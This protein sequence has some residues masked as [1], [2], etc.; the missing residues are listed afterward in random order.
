MD[1]TNSKDIVLT[2][3]GESWHE[4]GFEANPDP[5]AIGPVFKGD[6]G[7][8]IAAIKKT[9]AM[10]LKKAFATSGEFEL[11][12]AGGTKVTVTPEMVNFEESLPEMAA[13]AEFDAGTIYVDA[14][15]TR[16]I[17]SEGF[18]REVIRRVQ[19]MRKELDLAVDE[20][21]K[22]HIRVEDERVV[23]L[24]L[25]FEQYIAKEIRADVQVIGLDV[26]STGELSKDWEVEGISISIGISPSNGE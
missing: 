16:E 9:D 13:S 22:A 8:V 20:S 21:I 18:A 4:L 1:Q 19:D 7:K 6:A 24:I 26:D 14:K 2:G 12:I 11:E 17:E 10:A 25:D 23:D 3:V 5:S 15:L